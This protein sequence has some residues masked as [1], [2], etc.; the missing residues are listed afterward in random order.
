MPGMYRVMAFWTAVIAAL[1]FAGHMPVFALIFFANTA[2]FLGLSYMKISEKGYLYIFAGY[3]TLF[4]VS[5]TYY[6][7][8][9]M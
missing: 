6:T 3:L 5:F 7:Q 4:F 2:L 8:F 9:L 1:A